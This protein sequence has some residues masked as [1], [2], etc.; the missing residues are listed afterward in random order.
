V[1]SKRGSILGVNKYVFIR[2]HVQTEFGSHTASYKLYSG[3]LLP[4]LKRLKRKVDH[5]SPS[6]AEVRNAW[7]YTSTP[8]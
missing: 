4:R 1:F 6:N 8:L 2:H 5:S 7:S 3:D